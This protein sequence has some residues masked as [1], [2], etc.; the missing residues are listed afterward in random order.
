[1]LR[2]LQIGA[3]ELSWLQSGLSARAQALRLGLGIEP[4]WVGT[5]LGDGTP[6]LGWEVYDDAGNLS[7][8]LQTSPTTPNRLRKTTVP[9]LGVE[10]FGN[11]LE[12]AVGRIR[13][14]AGAFIPV[15]ADDTWY[16]L[17]AKYMLDVHEP[18]TLNL[19]AGST[20][21]TG[22]GTNFTRYAAT[23]SG[24]PR[25]MKVRIFDT[26]TVSGN[27][28]VYQ[29]A[30][31]TD[32]T[33]ATLVSAPPATE[34]G[35]R[36]R[37]HGDFLGAIPTDPD[38]HWNGRVAWELRTRTV[39]LPTDALI[40]YD[41]RR[42]SGSGTLSLLNRQ[43]AQVYRVNDGRNRAYTAGL[44]AGVDDS[45]AGAGAFM[46][47]K[48]TLYVW[49]ANETVTQITATPARAGYAGPSNPRNC[50][51]AGLLVEDSVTNTDRFVVLVG[52]PQVD[53]FGGV[54]GGTGRWDNAGYAGEV[55]VVSAVGL[56]GIALV[57]VPEVT[58]HT[59]LAFYSD[60]T[61]KIQM[62]TSADDGQTWVGPTAI[63]T[64]TAGNEAQASGLDAILTRSGRLIVV[65]PSGV[66]KA[67]RWIYSDNYGV[68]W[69]TNTA[70]GFLIADMNPKTLERPSIVEDDEGN[71]WTGAILGGTKA[72]I[73]RG[74]AVNT[75]TDDG[76]GGTEIG[77]KLPCEIASLSLLAAPIGANLMAFYDHDLAGD[78]A[79][80]YVSRCSIA[81]GLS[82][83][84]GRLVHTN[85]AAPFTAAS[86]VK[87]VQLADGSAWLICQNTDST[88]VLSYDLDLSVC[89]RPHGFRGGF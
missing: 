64:P 31:I 13:D 71:L 82:L 89:E 61:G 32:D 26:D 6:A 11:V 83:G 50:I 69:N 58:G 53:G 74:S 28:G 78:G 86:P 67:L 39:D 18:G 47:P 1:M 40:A 68:T 2:N 23:G 15:A 49:G 85:D 79:Q 56:R 10:P 41:V 29:F 25:S 65:A 45:T 21:I 55:A 24:D 4:G 5:F 75:P 37:V 73:F 77:P 38:S 63:W 22:V 8:R 57:A 66:T 48:S 54:F 27:G 87:A 44:V 36:F 88:L 81:N 19:T 35:V 43:H 42:A 72:T 30:T 12:V 60:S 14:S 9:F 70:D 59:H 80:R 7:V 3:P 62:K 34:T 46:P 76:G 17:V 20:T 84:H 16:T 51:L 52:N 33:N